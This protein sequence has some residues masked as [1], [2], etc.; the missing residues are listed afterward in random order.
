[1]VI[2]KTVAVVALVKACQAEEVGGRVA[3]R[4]GAFG[5]TTDGGGVVVEDGEGAFT[6]VNGL[7]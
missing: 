7:D 3:R 2:T 6:G 4:D 1:M 5:G